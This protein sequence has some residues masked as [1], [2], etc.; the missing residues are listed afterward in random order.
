MDSRNAAYRQIISVVIRREKHWYFGRLKKSGKFKIKKNIKK[1]DDVPNVDDYVSLK[2]CLEG[3]KL[4]RALRR[5][6]AESAFFLMKKEEEKVD[7]KSD[8]KLRI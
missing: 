2:R 7:D 8:D 3:D 5:M 6:K 4:K 1:I